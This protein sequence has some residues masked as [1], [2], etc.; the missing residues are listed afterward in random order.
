MGREHAAHTQ[1]DHICMPCSGNRASGNLKR[2]RP[3]GDDDDGDGKA[4]RSKAARDL[5]STWVD[6]TA[7]ELR[8]MGLPTL[9]KV[10]NNPVE[11]ERVRQQYPRLHAAHPPLPTMLL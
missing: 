7:S 9:A 2:H 8:E 4:P 1:P 10:K 11:W 5:I 3:G 6:K